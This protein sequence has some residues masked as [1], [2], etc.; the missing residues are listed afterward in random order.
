MR[1]ILHLRTISG[2]GGGPEKTL[3]AT[4]RHLGP[5]YEVRLAY[6][7][8]AGDEAYNMPQRAQQAGV[9]LIDIPETGPLDLR[10][11]WRLA[12]EIRGFQ[13]DLLHAHDYKTNVLAVILGRW[14]RVPV[15]TT[16]H[17]YV[18]LSPKL[19]RY[20]RIDRW[21]LRRMDHS[22]AVSADLYR[23]LE[24]LG[25]PA[26]QRSCVE[27]A[28]D[29]DVYRRPMNNGA[30]RSKLGV[31]P[32]RLLVGAVGRLQPEKGFDVLLETAEALLDQG[33]DFELV[34][35]GEGPERQRLESQIAAS[36][37]AARLR[38]LGYCAETWDLF[39]AL[40]LFVLSSLR[41]G[42]PNVLLEALAMEV[43]VVATEVGGISGLIRDGVDGL[44]VPPGDAQRLADG[45][46]RLFGDA[47]LR[48]R[49]AAA[50]RKRVEQGFDF[51]ERMRKIRAIYDRVLGGVR[52]S[53]QVAELAL[54]PELSKLGRGAG[55]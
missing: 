29:T 43:P 41:E 54:Q 37:H 4:P 49:L 18:T 38:L 36:S 55:K 19:N 22:I 6:L 48:A 25:I 46:A 40:D 17:G 39:A 5:E 3:L 47:T 8:P 42:L 12:G 13:P 33:W 31:V 34:I 27:N 52:D 26:Q 11:V 2:R 10:A 15:V 1:K 23:F 51:A 7:R 21:A 20:Y 44:L 14:F 30:A 35:V 32:G 45:M 50:G 53:D 24:E 28:I 9:Q 16:L